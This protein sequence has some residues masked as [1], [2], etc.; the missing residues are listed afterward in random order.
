MY[1]KKLRVNERKIT[2]ETELE[3]FLLMNAFTCEIENT[4]LQVEFS[5]ERA[6]FIGWIEEEGEVYYLDN[7]SGDEEPYELLSDTCPEERMMCYQAS[8]IRMIV[9][10]FCETGSRHP[11]FQWIREEDNF[12]WTNYVPKKERMFNPDHIPD[13]YE[14]MHELGFLY[15]NPNA[16]WMPEMEWMPYE[17]VLHS[18]PEDNVTNAVLPFAF[19]G[20][21]DPYVFIE[22]GSYEPYIGRHFEPEPDGEYYAFN[23]EDAIFRTII[24]YAEE[25]AIWLD[26][27]WNLKNPLESVDDCLKERH[28]QLLKYCQIYDSLLRPSYLDVIERLATLPYQKCTFDGNGHW[29]ALLS[30]K[31]AEAL[32]MQYLY[33]DLINKPFPWYLDEED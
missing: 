18:Q 24:E 17:K 13:L 28:E 2:N 26:E 12:D 33:F 32:I 9:S 10:Y 11:Q 7:G 23:F 14:K 19:T 27:N 21:G 3:P 20:G 15:P 25:P 31:E 22:N 16:V 8:D 1:H 5:E 30:A 4:A 29:L 6:A